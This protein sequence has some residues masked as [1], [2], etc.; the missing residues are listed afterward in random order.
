MASDGLK[1]A[2]QLGWI[3]VI[4]GAIY[5]GWIFYSRHAANQEQERE[6]AAKEAELNRQIL[7]KVGGESLKITSF[8]ANPG[9]TTKGNPILLCYGVVNAT[10]VS[11]EP[12][13]PDVHPSLSYCAET[14][15]NRSVTYILT[16]EDNSGNKVSAEAK[17]TVR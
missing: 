16:A 1:R 13:G 14:K 6:K 12:D 4:L 15:P 3:P 10:R 8:Y 9:V 17:V 2:V 11:I 7:D 5:V